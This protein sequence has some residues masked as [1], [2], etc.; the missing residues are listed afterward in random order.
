MLYCVGEAHKVGVTVPADLLN[1]SESAARG[2]AEG[3]GHDEA[4]LL[5]V[6]PSEGCQQTQGH[7]RPA[8]QTDR[9]D[10]SHRVLP[11][12]R[13]PGEVPREL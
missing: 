1:D 5:R 8:P 12:L 4:E 13:G 10:P 6:P 2:T 9:T 7:H 3:G 11:L